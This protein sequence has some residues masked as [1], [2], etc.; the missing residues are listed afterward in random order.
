MVTTQGAGRPRSSQRRRPGE[1][2]REEILDAAAE[3]FT[4]HGYASTST[5]KI[6]EAVGV[7]QATIYHYFGTKDDI[8]EALLSGTVSHTLDAASALFATTGDPAARLHS[9][10]W[11]DGIQLWNS[12]WNIGALYLLPELRAE[13]FAPFVASRDELRQVYRDRTADVITL[14]DSDA[15][16]S[17]HAYQEEDIP[18][19]LVE[20]LVNM[21]WD[22]RGEVDEPFRTA[23][24]IL[25]AIGWR[26]NW[27]ILQ[28]ESHRA[29]C[30][31]LDPAEIIAKR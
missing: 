1:T 8:L 12:H 25:R 19:R 16:A 21:R 26:G 24:S 18:L 10:A 20:T 5:R 2:A 23:N 6:A 11:Y 28:K 30:T 22:G 14:A 3:L 29:L 7:R 31:I 17:P 27:E 9:L 4:T 13:R 15:T